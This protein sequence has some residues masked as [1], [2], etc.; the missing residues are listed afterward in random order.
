LSHCKISRDKGKQHITSRVVSGGTTSS[1]THTVIT[2][3]RNMATGLLNTDMAL[4][5]IQDGMNE[6]MMKV[7]EPIITE[8]LK[9]I[10]AEMRLK[11][12]G[13]VIGLM[14]HYMECES[15]RDTIRITIKKDI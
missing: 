5:I 3:G 6:E 8:T 2:K 4:K 11:L 10:E 15:N 12:G 7:A 1:P 9:K 14:D 13:M